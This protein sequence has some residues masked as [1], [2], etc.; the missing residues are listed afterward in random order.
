MSDKHPQNA[1]I[2]SY[3]R[4]LAASLARLPHP[5]PSADL[6][7]RI[8]AFAVRQPQQKAPFRLQVWAQQF[9]HE[10]LAPIPAGMAQKSALAALILMVGMAGYAGETLMASQQGYSIEDDE[11][12]LITALA[13][14]DTLYELEGL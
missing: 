7:D 4:E 2:D 8:V 13:Y 3:E 10:L 14:D 12:Y 1:D 6:A 9:M 5:A 11:S